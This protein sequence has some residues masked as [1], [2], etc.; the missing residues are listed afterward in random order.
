MSSKSNNQPRDAP[1]TSFV[2]D[3][4]LTNI[5]TNDQFGVVLVAAWPPNQ[6]FLE[7]YELFIN[8]VK[9]CFDSS[10]LEYMNEL[11]QL[12]DQGGH[13]E[14]ESTITSLNNNDDNENDYDKANDSHKSETMTPNV[15]LYPPRHMHITVAS[16]HQFNKSFDAGYD[17]ESYLKACQQIVQNAMKR[18]DWPKNK[19]N[20]KVDRAQ[21][22]EKAGILLWKDSNNDEGNGS[23]FHLIR[24][25]VREEYEKFVT[26]MTANSD[27][28]SCCKMGIIPKGKEVIIPGII[29]ST[30]LRFGGKP[31]TDGKV[32]QDRFQSLVMKNMENIFNKSVSID[33]V[34]L[35]V[36]KKAYMHIPSDEGHILESSELSL[37]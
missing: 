13:N 22:G 25:I 24:K 6:S 7:P 35:V 26:T 1:S 11:D 33:S 31:S 34:K 17:H 9:Q 4:Y 20:V 12:N 28:S 36:E 18:S 27:T 32:I 5:Y 10:D 15:Y 16:F 21:I 23:S 30:F 19:F 29:H 2:V 8:Q 3:P 37:S 14:N